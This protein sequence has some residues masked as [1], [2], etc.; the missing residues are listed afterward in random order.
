MA[1]HIIHPIPL[2]LLARSMHEQV[3]RVGAY[4][5]QVAID[6]VYLWYIEGT[7]QNIV[8]DTGMTA[9]MLKNANVPGLSTGV[10]HIQTL[11]EGLG[12]YGLKPEDIDLVIMTHC[13]V[14]HIPLAHKF[15]NAKFLVQQAELDYHRTPPPA[16]VDPRP[17]PKELLDTLNWEVVNG[18]YQIEEGIKVLLTP[19]HTPGGQS[20]AVDTVKGVAILDS[21]CTTDANWDVPPSLEERMEVLCPGIHSDPV[22]AYESL[23]RVKEM[24]DIR[25]PI[26]E[27]RFAWIDRIPD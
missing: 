17:C 5:G 2:M 24:A 16:P 14:D 7:K 10:I 9:E 11:E 4:V 23:I 21:L 13:H 25:V 18:D 26:H 22:Q 6:G 20:V 12:K 3:Y 1:E 15:R 19:G 8:V 27:P